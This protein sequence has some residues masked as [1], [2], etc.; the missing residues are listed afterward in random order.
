MAAQHHRPSLR[1]L[2]GWPTLGSR[3]TIAIALV[4][5]SG[6]FALRVS[7]PRVVNSDEI[8]FVVPVAMLALRFGLRG[9]L[10][11]ALL[12]LVLVGEWDLHENGVAVSLQGYLSVGGAFVLLG[13]LLGLF[14][15]H[16]RTLEAEISSSFDASLDLL[17][18]ADLNGRFIRVNPAW[19]RLLGHSAETICSRPFIDFVHPED[20]EATIAEAAALA[21]GSRD[22]VRFRNRYRA[23][24]GS[25]RLLEWSAH[26]SP[27]E[28]VIHAV[29]RDITV[30]VQ[31][32]EQLADNAEL[33]QT[34]VAERTRD[35]EDARAEDL[36]RL[37]IAAEYRDDDTFEHTERVGE[38]AVQIGARLGLTDEELEILRKSAPLHD[39]GKLAI[40]DS[41]LLKRG[42]LTPEEH[43]VMET[44][45]EL[46][47]RLL[48][49]S[50]APV[51][52]M[53]SV[54]AASHH[55]RWDGAGYPAKLAGEAIPL[56][57]R[58]VAVADVFDALTHDRPYKSAW[59]VEQAI[60][61]IQRGAGSQF[62]ARVVGAFLAGHE[63][64]SGAGHGWL[65][66]RQRATPARARRATATAH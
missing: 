16:R 45:A 61:E 17:G 20:H 37:A 57:G 46:G 22:T 31:A 13:T 12:A 3:T 64:A 39:I 59:P 24:D 29:A 36:K 19:E 60:A 34:M 10:A 27:S 42:R 40:P 51:L 25:Y 7:D 52:Q 11:G 65:Q 18:T 8:L 47:A 30:Q 1:R 44:H 33:L 32:E 38:S 14:V 26:G 66:D 28:G 5:F 50:K 9:G 15:D 21:E 58:I 55:E 41:I 62:D 23:A 54:I 35:L 53:A 48:G 6:I 2:R 63:D 4:L 49:G 56:V 43:V